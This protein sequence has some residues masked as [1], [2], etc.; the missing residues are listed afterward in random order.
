[1]WLHPLQNHGFWMFLDSVSVEKN[2][3]EA[4]QIETWFS[5]GAEFNNV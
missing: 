4:D 3:G 1:M 5:A 2:S